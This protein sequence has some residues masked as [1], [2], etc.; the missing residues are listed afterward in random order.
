MKNVSFLAHTHDPQSIIPKTIPG[1]PWIYPENFNTILKPVSWVINKQTNKHTST[2][3]SHY[4]IDVCVSQFSLATEHRHLSKTWQSCVQFAKGQS[5]VG[6]W[7]S[8]WGRQLSEGGQ[9]TEKCSRSVHLYCRQQ[10]RRTCQQNCHCHCQMSVYLLYWRS[11]FNA[12]INF[13]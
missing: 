7:S 4:V 12:V 10:H 1:A 6:T 13:S 8:V 3:K 2:H 9:C 5:A 11:L